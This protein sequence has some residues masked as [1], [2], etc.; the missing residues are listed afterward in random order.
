MGRDDGKP[1]A[2]AHAL[3]FSR[4]VFLVYLK[5]PSDG[6]EA[7]KYVESMRAYSRERPRAGDCQQ[8]PCSPPPFP[9]GTELALVRRAIL[10]DA[11]GRPVVSLIT[12]SAQLRRYVSIW[13]GG[14][15]DFDGSTQ[16]VAE[17]QLTRSGFLQGTIGL[18]RVKK[19]KLSLPYS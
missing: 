8:N 14:S 16:Q 11:A 17:F 1:A 2:A 18:R 6:I 10:M 3:F 12:E 19:T 13:A 5:L 15:I 4:S 9:V 7:T